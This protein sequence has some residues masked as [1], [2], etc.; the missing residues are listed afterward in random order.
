MPDCD[1]FPEGHVIS[2]RT[3]RSRRGDE[4][5]LER[6]MTVD[7]LA[8]VSRTPSW[9]A[10]LPRQSASSV[11][12]AKVYELLSDGTLDSH[13]HRQ[14]SSNNTQFV[15]PADRVLMAALGALEKHYGK[16]TR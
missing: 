12:S 15:S 16:G 9:T 13:L 2:R 3:G 4:E 7:Q 14:T 8:D 10:S 5:R 6:F 1:D 11:G